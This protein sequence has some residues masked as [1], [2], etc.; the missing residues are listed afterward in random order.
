MNCGFECSWSSFFKQKINR[1]PL[2]NITLTFLNES[3][4]GEAMITPYGIEGAPIY[5]LSREIRNNI[6]KNN[7]AIVF[8]DLCPD[9]NKSEILNRI[10]QSPGKNSFSN[11]L[12]KQL[13]I[14]TVK[15]S[16]LR[17]LSEKST[18][19]NFNLLSQTIKKLPLILER[20]R[21]IDE[22]ISSSGG[23]SFNDLDD[24]FMLKKYQGWFT[25]GEMVDWDAPTGGYLLQGCFSTAFRVVEGIKKL[26]N[27]PENAEYDQFSP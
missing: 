2:K 22:A 4:R 20:P 24:Y 15:I 9:L 25:A 16:L 14:S 8:I 27:F 18:F 11:H 17:E 1:L 10:S 26:F 5:K 7:K 12:R 19:K 21:P 13:N 6:E 23:V 3:I